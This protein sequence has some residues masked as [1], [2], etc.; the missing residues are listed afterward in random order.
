M[1]TEG[2]RRAAAASEERAE[3]L[4]KQVAE[5]EEGVARAEEG[6]ARAEEVLRVQEAN[7]LQDKQAAVMVCVCVCAWKLKG[8]LISISI[9][10]S[11]PTLT[12][13]KAHH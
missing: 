13:P 6:V 2:N 1:D 8:I 11:I 5:L 4:L 9:S 7:K 10:N 12:Y 3:L